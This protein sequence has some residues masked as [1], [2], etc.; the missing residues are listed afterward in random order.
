[1][2]VL[3]TNPSSP[4]SSPTLWRL[5]DSA[6]NTDAPVLL[7]DGV[8][9]WRDVYQ[10][11]PGFAYWSY[12]A[13]KNLKPTHW[14]PLPP[15]PH[16]PSSQAQSAPDRSDNEKTRDLDNMK[17]YSPRPN[18]QNPCLRQDAGQEERE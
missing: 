18:L 14:M 10:S 15:A 11:G 7:S 12:A 1:M 6:P 9:V 13:E 5:L 3:P 4:S 16:T 17:D 8:N 2:S